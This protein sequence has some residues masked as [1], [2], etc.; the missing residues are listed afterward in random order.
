VRAKVINCFV[1]PKKTKHFIENIFFH[2]WFFSTNKI[3][4]FEFYQW[5]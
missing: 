1:L 2:Y 3:I 4:I 5:L